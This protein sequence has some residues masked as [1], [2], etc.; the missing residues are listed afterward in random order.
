M[1]GYDHPGA[2]NHHSQSYSPAL[3]SAHE[4]ITD[5]THCKFFRCWTILLQKSFCNTIGP[6]ADTRERDGAAL[7]ARGTSRVVGSYSGG[8]SLNTINIE[9]LPCWRSAGAMLS[10]VIGAENCGRMLDPVGIAIYCVPST[11]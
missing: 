3:I 4:R 10:G 8:G 5:G 6:E 11:I 9:P 7:Q 1:D 2:Q